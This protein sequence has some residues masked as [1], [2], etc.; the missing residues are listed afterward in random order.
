MPVQAVIFLHLALLPGTRLAQWQSHLSRCWLACLTFL[1]WTD[2]VSNPSC[3]S[4]KQ[5]CCCPLCLSL[6]PLHTPP[7]GRSIQGHVNA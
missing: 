3:S 2:A 6:L 4:I 1:L 5:Y 7:C